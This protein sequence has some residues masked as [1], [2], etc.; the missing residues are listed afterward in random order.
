MMCEVSLIGLKGLLILLVYWLYWMEWNGSRAAYRRA[1]MPHI[2]R[3][4]QLR[5][6][7]NGTAARLH[8][9]WNGS[10][11]AYRMNGQLGCTSMAYERLCRI[12]NGIRMGIIWMAYRTAYWMAYRTAY[13]MAYWMAYGWAYE[14][15]IEWAA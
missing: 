11:A 3:D 5:C 9:E 12:S 10:C 6:I 1:A 14:W 15:R 13:W 4:G 8:I 7:L 2:E